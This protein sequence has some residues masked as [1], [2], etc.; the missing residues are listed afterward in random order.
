MRG[1]EIELYLDRGVEMEKYILSGD[2]NG[3]LGVEVKMGYEEC[4]EWGDDGM[5]I[6][7]SV[8]GEFMKEGGEGK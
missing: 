7:E 8:G 6:E 3:F 5:E 4:G 2:K 1:I